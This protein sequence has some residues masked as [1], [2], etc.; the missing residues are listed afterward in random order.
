MFIAVSVFSNKRS[1][2]LMNL[3]PPPDDATNIKDHGSGHG[4]NML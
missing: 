4:G 1:L 3:A 2:V